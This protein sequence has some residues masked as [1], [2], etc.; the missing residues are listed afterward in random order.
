MQPPRINFQRVCLMM[1]TVCALGAA[2]RPCW[3]GLNLLREPGRLRAISLPS[4]PAEEDPVSADEAG[5]AEVLMLQA[6]GAAAPTEGFPRQKIEEVAQALRKIAK[7]QE[8]AE[9]RRL[10]NE[11]ALA[12]SQTPR[13]RKLIALGIALATGWMLAA[14]L[15]WRRL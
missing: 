7:A 10:E 11:L 14:G 12:E 3:I 9:R 5:K 6:A 4:A 1:M 13:G 8:A 2:A 15:I